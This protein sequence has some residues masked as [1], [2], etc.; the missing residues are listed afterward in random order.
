MDASEELYSRFEAWESGTLPPEIANAF[1]NRLK[2][3]PHLQETVTFYVNAREVPLQEQAG[4]IRSQVDAAYTAYRKKRK[5]RSFRGFSIAATLLLGGLITYLLTSHPP[6]LQELYTSHYERP[7]VNM[8]S[9]ENGLQKDWETALS[10]FQDPQAQNLDSALYRFELL[11]QQP[12]F[13]ERN[14]AHLYTGIC[15]LETYQPDSA[16][17]AFRRVDPFSILCSEHALWLEGLA[18]LQKEECEA[19]KQIFSSLQEEDKISKRKQ[20]EAKIISDQLNCE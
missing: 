16:I 13:K 4:R 7:G 2:T 1:E 9:V 15:Y 14:A 12:N 3:D 6:T 8:R 20:Q 17:A 11:L 18:W 10:F 5:K 19:A